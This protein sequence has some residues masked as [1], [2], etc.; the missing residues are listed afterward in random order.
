MAD[1]VLSW[2][3]SYG[4]RLTRK[5]RVLAAAYGDGYQQL[6]PDGIHNDPQSWAVQYDVRSP[7]E[8]DDIEDFLA[9]R[10]GAEAFFWVSLE[11]EVIRVRAAQWDRTPNSAAAEILSVTLEQIFDGTPDSASVLLA[12]DDIVMGA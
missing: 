8:T 2:L 5:P 11:G 4:A 7:E 6:T 9:A 1:L 12:A 3:P 10:A